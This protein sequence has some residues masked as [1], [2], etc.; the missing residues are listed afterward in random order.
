MGNGYAPTIT[1]RNADGEVVFSESVPFLPQDTNM[2]SLGVVKVPDGLPEQL[3]T[4]RLLLPD[5]G[6]ADHGRVHVGY[7][8]LST[9]C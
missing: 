8:A 9:R 2:T 7:P 4:R 5:P 6:A 1:I 3:G